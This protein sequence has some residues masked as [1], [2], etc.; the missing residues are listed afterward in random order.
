MKKN[1]YIICTYD[2][3]KHVD[4]YNKTKIIN[5]KTINFNR[6]L[7][8]TMHCFDKDNKKILLNEYILSD[9][10]KKFKNDLLFVIFDKIYKNVKIE[11]YILVATLIT[12]NENHDILGIKCITDNPILYI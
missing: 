7:S 4:F 8:D 2:V 9:L 6:L 12:R 3:H 10:T 1:D 5:G 11:N